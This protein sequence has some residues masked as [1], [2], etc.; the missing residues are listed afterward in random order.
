MYGFSKI[1]LDFTVERAAEAMPQ[2]PRVSECVGLINHYIQRTVA[3]W[4][5]ADYSKRLADAVSWLAVMALQHRQVMIASRLRQIAAQLDT[6][7][8]G[9]PLPERVLT[10]VGVDAHAW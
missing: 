2:D 8:Q 10:N 4:P 1:L 5:T 6:S 3:E 9:L 7:G